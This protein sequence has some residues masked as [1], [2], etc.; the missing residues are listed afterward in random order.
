MTQPKVLVELTIEHA[1]AVASLLDLA[2]RIEMGQIEEISSLM[3]EGRIV[4]RAGSDASPATGDESDAADEVCASL[5]NLLGH[6][7]S[8]SFGIGSPHVPAEAK[9]GYEAMKAIQQALHM[10]L[11]PDV[12]HDVRRDGVTVRY[13]AGEVPTARIS[14]R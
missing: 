14:R 3:R 7:R 2:T 8:G 10:H 5:K 13:A 4:V 11:R 6:P 12:R 9:R 1:E